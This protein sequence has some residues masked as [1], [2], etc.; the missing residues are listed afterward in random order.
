MLFQKKDSAAVLR[1]I[2]V[3]CGKVGSNLVASLSQEGHNITIIDKRSDKVQE[4]SNLYDV[5]GIVGNGAS[6]SIQMEAGIGTA[7]LF[8]AVTDSDELNLLCCTVAKRVGDCAAIARVRDPDYSKEISYL[9]QKLG[10]A[11]VINPELEMAREASKILTLPAA[12]DTNSFAHGMA[13]MIKVR[14][15]KDNKLCGKTLAQCS[16]LTEGK[17]L[18]CAVER[19]GEVI[20]PS[21][22]FMLQEDDLISLLSTRKNLRTFLGKVGFSTGKVRNCLIVGGG[23]AAYYLASHLLH[24]GID[25]KIIER[26][27]ARC[28]EL[29]ILL[30]NAVIINGD[31]SDQALLKEEGIE[32]TESFISLTGID[33]ENVFLTLYAKQVSQAKVITKINRIS[34]T[35]VINSLDLGSVIYPKNI[36]A[37]AIL[38]YVRA[39]QNSMGSN[40]ETLYHLFE[41]HAEALEFRAKEDPKL[42]NIP[43]M[44]LPLKD[45]LLI[46]CISRGG[47]ILI[48]RGMDHIQAGDTV[49]VVTTHTGFHDLHDILR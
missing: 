22:G 3:G 38:A 18:I 36:T 23:K 15:S 25:V 39:K 13:E 44:N 17:T 7:D 10:L 24:N 41:N 26:D 31:G 30:P 43:L 11:M 4:I 32:D 46:C 49:T 20:I 6:Y 34:F 37:E 12:L 29:S 40:V 19:D 8:I 21:G 9:Q 2:I 16:T 35:D 14:L 5:M 28:D 45:N 1:I 47:N 48:P 33:E 42:T 27:H